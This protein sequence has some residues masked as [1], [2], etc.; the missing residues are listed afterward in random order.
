MSENN[1]QFIPEVEAEAIDLN[2]I[3]RLGIA[4]VIMRNKII[5]LKTQIELKEKQFKHLS[6]VAI[7][8]MMQTAHMKSFGLQNGFKFEVSPVVMVTLPKENADAADEWLD[9]NGHS[10]MVKHHLDI[11]LPK[12][13][14]REKIDNL[15]SWIVKWGYECSENKSIHYQTLLKWGR[16]MDEEGEIIPEDIFKVYRGYKTEIKG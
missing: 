14:D 4:Y 15:K 10:G 16:E 13:T 3:S 8:E 7:P 11:H 5:Q 9:E 1:D 6:E 12:G 2:R